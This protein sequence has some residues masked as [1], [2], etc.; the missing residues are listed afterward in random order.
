MKNPCRHSAKN[1]IDLGGILW[2][3]ECG[4]VYTTY[5]NRVKARWMSPVCSVYDLNHVRNYGIKVGRKQLQEE[6]LEL[7]GVNDVITEAQ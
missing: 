2:C 1:T 3:K 4:A 7:L 6:L 5:P